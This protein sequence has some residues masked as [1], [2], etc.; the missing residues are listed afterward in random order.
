[1]DPVLLLALVLVVVYMGSCLVHPYMR[2]SRCNRSKESH[3]M[4]FKGAFGACRACNGRGYHLRFGARL[5]GRK[6]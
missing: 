2:C 3:S 6:L 1:M 4:V 5:L